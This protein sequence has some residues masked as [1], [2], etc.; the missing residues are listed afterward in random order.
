[1]KLASIRSTEIFALQEQSWHEKVWHKFV[2]HNLGWYQIVVD[3][4]VD[5]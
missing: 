1:M 3:V 4:Q 5:T 2:Y